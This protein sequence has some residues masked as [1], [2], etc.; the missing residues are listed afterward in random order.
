MAHRH[1][2]IKAKSKC[3]QKNQIK[4]MLSMRKQVNYRAS[5]EESLSYHIYNRSINKE[6][7]FK[8]DKD[9]K[10]FLRKCKTLLLPFFKIEAYCIMPNHF[11]FLVYVKPITDEILIK[12]KC[13]K[14][15]A[16]IKFQR[17]E[18]PYHDFLVDQ[19]KRLFQSYALLYNRQEERNGSVFQKGFKRILIK[20]EY[21]WYHILAYI[22]HNP[23]HHKFR[24]KYKDWKYCS[25][26]AFLSD[27]SSS[28]ARE[29]VL[30]RF[31]EN[32]EKAKKEYLVLHQ[33]FKLDKKMSEFYLD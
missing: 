20:D 9:F 26:L 1:G 5:F 7:I 15:L 12:I 22:H 2:F 27:S 28:V 17:K 23:I 25:Y 14:T 13:Q 4:T 21:R 6:T 3:H 19:F 31:D 29:W 33:G 32:I 18:I 24:E 11:H 16:S 30:A 10:L 8:E